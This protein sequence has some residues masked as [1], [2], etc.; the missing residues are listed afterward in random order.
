[1]AT[2][3]THR[4]GPAPDDSASACRRLRDP[5]RTPRPTRRAPGRRPAPLR[6]SPRPPGTQ[7]LGM[8]NFSVRLTPAGRGFGACEDPGHGPGSADNHRGTG[9]RPVCAG[10][11]RN[12]N[13]CAAVQFA[14]VA[15]RP[16][17][18]TVLGP[19]CPHPPGG[20]AWHFALL[21]PLHL[22]VT[23]ARKPWSRVEL[24]PVTAPDP[25][26]PG[27]LTRGTSEQTTDERC[28]RF[29]DDGP[30]RKRTT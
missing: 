29:R 3:S 8:V 10:T 17:A 22:T 24:L 19:Q 2:R 16:T 26:S 30:T 18:H 5:P 7:S 15:E 25:G 28:D 14:Q 12:S 1:M 11:C 9:A 27:K 21:M 20:P 6:A 23:F 4:V 13:G